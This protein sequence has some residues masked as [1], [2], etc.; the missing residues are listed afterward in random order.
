MLGLDHFKTIN[1]RHDRTEL[2]QGLT[3]RCGR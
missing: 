2:A 1:D 3:R